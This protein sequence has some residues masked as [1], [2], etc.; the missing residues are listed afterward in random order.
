MGMIVP[1]LLT[2]FSSEQGYKL[3]DDAMP[4]SM[5]PSYLCLSR[6]H[7]FEPASPLILYNLAPF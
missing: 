7:R 1:A 3:F 2:R 5:C 6:E 4:T